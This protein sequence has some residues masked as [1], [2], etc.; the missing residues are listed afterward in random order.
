MKTRNLF[1]ISLVWFHF[2]I[3]TYSQITSNPFCANSPTYESIELGFGS[4]RYHVNWFK[5]DSAGVYDFSGT[6]IIANI[7]GSTGIEPII[8]F[9]CTPRIQD[10]TANADTTGWSH[11]EKVLWERIHDSSLPSPETSWFPGDT[12]AWKNFLTAFTE[13]YNGDGVN[14]YPG[15]VHPFRVYQL[16]V[17]MTRIWCTNNNESFPDDY[18]RYINMSYRTIKEADPNALVKMAGWGS[19]DVHLFYLNYIETDSI[20]INQN[21]Y[22]QRHHLDTSQQYQ[23]NLNN[24]LYIFENTDYDAFDIHCYGLAE[25]FPGRA[26]GLK[27]LFDTAG[28]KSLWALEGGGP[29]RYKA[30][31][32]N[33]IN[34]TGYLSPQ[35][36]MENA[37]YVIRYFVGGIGS[38]F[39]RL[40]W[41]VG[42]EYDPWGQEFGDLNL[43]SINFEKKPSYWVYKGLASAIS[44]YTDAAP[45]TNGLYWDNENIVGYRIQASS[46]NYIFIWNL[47]DSASVTLKGINKQLI[48]PTIMGDSLWTE[49]ILNSDSIYAFNTSR[50]PLIFEGSMVPT[51]TE[52]EFYKYELIM[53]FPNPSSNILR[54]NISRCLKNGTIIIYDNL[55]QSVRTFTNIYGDELRISI[56][57]L[58][59]GFYHLIIS[60]GN[61]YLGYKKFVK[62]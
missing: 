38:G 47:I 5:F 54:L 42:P 59:D 19:I 2:N 20:P 40:A 48:Y 16:E 8:I 49:I 60:E 61:S 15:L 9:K 21:L 10:T 62:N 55:G 24:W 26:V 39:T 17:E 44:N 45:I 28:I 4:Y 32:F 6:D 53:L 27:S 3:S 22:I 1:L 41:N 31:V 37:A 50:L 11:C 34:D 29:F 52:E 23:Q 12:I 58:P 51:S 33:P 46:H 30:E 13:R 25:H 7:Y 43:M 57:N 56:E 36:V 18:V 35:L 14:D